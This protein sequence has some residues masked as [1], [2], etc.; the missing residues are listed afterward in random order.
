MEAKMR[1]GLFPNGITLQT[2]PGNVSG[3]MNRRNYDDLDLPECV[4]RYLQFAIPEETP[5]IRQG[6]IFQRGKFRAGLWSSFEA[7]QTFTTDP[8][9]FLWSARIR[10][11][12]LL[13]VNVRDSY[14][15]GKGSMEARMLGIIPLVN[16]AE[17]TEINAGALQRYLA[18]SVWFPTVLM[19]GAFVRWTEIGDNRAVATMRDGNLEVSLEFQFNE[20]GEIIGTYSPGRFRYAG[21]KYI[22]TPWSGSFS[23]YRQTHGFQIPTQCEVEWELPEGRYPYFRATIEKVDYNVACSAMTQ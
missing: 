19:P 1:D 9:S 17:T 20:R 8:A 18:E 11:G 7:E 3:L 23:N 4:M 21:G 5:R 10:M 12:G 14:L 15:E 22:L 13:P 16:Q 2:G 6:K